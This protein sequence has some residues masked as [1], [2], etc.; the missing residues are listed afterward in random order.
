MVT[1]RTNG[2]GTAHRRWAVL[3][4]GL[5]VGLSALGG[6]GRPTAAAPDAPEGDADILFADDFSD[7]NS[8]WIIYFLNNSI[9][10]YADGTYQIELYA[11]DLVS[12]GSLLRHSFT[13]FDVRF[14]GRSTVPTFDSRIWYSFFFR[15]QHTD[16]IYGFYA[17][18]VSPN[19]QW[20]RLNK[21][22]TNEF[23]ELVPLTRSTAIHP[24]WQDNQLRVVAK[25]SQITIYANG[26]ELASVTDGTWT[27]G[28]FAFAAGNYGRPEGMHG[29]LDNVVA[30]T[31][32][33]GTPVPSP[34]DR[35]IL[36]A[37]T[38]TREPARPTNTRPPTTATEPGP[39]ATLSETPPPTATTLPRTLVP[40]TVTN[41][42]SPLPTTPVA[43][44]VIP[45]PTPR[46]TTPVATAVIPSP[47]PRPTTPVAEPTPTI[48]ASVRVCP[49]VPG[50]VPAE[51]LARALTHPEEFAGW[52]QLCNPALP[53]SPWNGYRSSLTMQYPSR[54]YQ[55]T[56]NSLVF[57]CGCN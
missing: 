48:S 29:T 19:G 18:D 28:T 34:T 43:T 3:V 5:L 39:T 13:D 26:Q 4:V 8:G 20:Y 21:W 14:T 52:G 17:F 7:P 38:P 49:G 6:M 46:P 23:F 30:Y 42:P 15:Y 10:Y 25:G 45:S 24:T 12:Y 1:R 9:G 16:Q 22:V 36:T 37:V 32:D 35:P 51:V 55:P 53:P 31:V 47:T 27:E 11:Q 50:R 44:A 56:F 33:D 40:P 57:K 2:W 41:L 54:P